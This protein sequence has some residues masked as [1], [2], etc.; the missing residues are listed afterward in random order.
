[1]ILSNAEIYKAITSGRIKITPTP[2]VPTL[3]DSDTPYNTTALDLRLGNTISLPKENQPYTFDLTAGKVAEFFKNNYD[4]HEITKEGGF[5]LKPGQFAIANT[6]ESVELVISDG[7]PS[8]AARVEGKSSFARCGLL[9]HFTAP[10]I[11]AGFSGT[12]TLELLNLG[13]NKIHLV[14][15]MYICQLIFEKVEGEILFTPSQF[16]GQSTP[17][18]Q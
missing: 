12:I 11:H 14:P 15:G 9:V 18:G 16:Q 6:L 10:T 13:A 8:Y 2:K 1:M 17:E 3:D 4:S 5:A 7:G